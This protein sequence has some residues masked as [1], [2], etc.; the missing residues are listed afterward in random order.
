MNQGNFTVRLIYMNKPSPHRTENPV[1]LD[2]MK[3]AVE[4]SMDGIA[5]L[6]AS[7]K[8][9]YLNEVHIRMF[10]Y[11]ME[12][13]LIGQSWQFIYD[14]PEI[15][16]IDKEIFPVLMKEGKWRGETIGKS[17]TG[18][19]VYQDISLTI[20]DD[21]GI[22]CICRDLAQ[23]IM[24]D[25][26]IRISGKILEQS[27]SMLMTTDKNRNITWVNKAFTTITGYT[28]EEVIGK[29]P[30][31]LLQ[32]PMSKPDTIQQFREALAAGTDFDCELINY[33]KDNSPYWVNIR[34]QAFTDNEGNV[35][36]YFAIEEDITL[37]K[38][39]A[40]L[41]AES[42]RRLEV[43]INATGA[44]LWE[45]DINSNT[46]YYSPT[47]KKVLGYED[48]EIQLGL[49]E[50]LE[51]IHPED[52]TKTMNQLNDCLNGKVDTYEAELRLRHK[53]GH[54]IHVLDRGKITRL[55][56]DGRPSRM[57][58]IAFD[59]TLLKETQQKLKESEA[60]WNA[61]L[62][63]SEFGVWEWDLQSNELYFSPKLKELYGY[64]QDELQPTTAFWTD[65]CHPDDLHDSKNEL[66][67]L[68]S[69]ATDKFK[70]D[71][72]V[73]HRNGQ[74]KWFRSVGVI[75][76]RDD[77]GVPVKLVGSVTDITAQKNM[78]DD[79][80]HAKTVAESNVH[81]KRR[82]LAN[83]SHEIR[84]PIHAV[85]GIAEQLSQTKLDE[86]QRDY[87]SIIEDSSHALLGI[88]NDVLDMAKIE[89]GKLRINNEEFRLRPL[90]NSVYQLYN[91]KAAQKG[92]QFTVE[93]DDTLDRLFMG[94]PFRVRQIILNIVSNAVKFTEKGT[95][96]LKCSCKSV[97][98][99][100]FTVLLEC[101]DT[102][103]GMS[104]DMKQRLFQ[105]FS[106][107]DDSFERRYGGSGL[108][109]AITHEL[110]QL[111]GGTIEVKSDKN[112]G[113]SIGILL[114][115]AGAKSMTEEQPATDDKAT[116]YLPMTS[117]H[118]LIAEDNKFNRL[119]IQIMM[120]NNKIS[121]DLAD[122]GAQAVELASSKKYDLVLMD[123]QMPEMDGVEATKKIRTLPG[124]DLPIIAITANA[125]EEE[126]RSYVEQ[127]MSGYLT[128]PFDEMQL[129]EKIK[130]FIR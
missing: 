17:K 37:R 63:G 12:A 95:I 73:Y 28:I 101:T 109:L 32:G 31:H 98:Q 9:Y 108:G 25:Q 87:V 127:G 130:E 70:T 52:H 90:L 94:D 119:L 121:Y 92:L 16:R 46:V 85:M 118:V 100:Q 68:L 38:Q 99:Q 129:M 113:T 15:E 74:L 111:M 55:D 126:L 120:E 47:W 44:A 30:G 107:E 13:E 114:P 128:K 58:G 2:K 36:G 123:I 82:F 105:D 104:E 79:L 42:N 33:K 116:K 93:F 117:L 48:E 40:E 39:T 106:Q 65:T 18:E 11:E 72:R 6:D 35:E 75:S 78:E 110:V 84:T 69:G 96:Q 122:N 88:I 71:R 19:P 51:R 125:V 1:F 62:E 86:K 10:G 34:C 20:L 29:N 60:R 64:K 54:Y 53:N 103:I 43:A 57:T 27:N 23:R 50:W 41:L 76:N 7:G 112:T 59:I 24:A 66:D 89:E 22:I 21:G 67:K 80:I 3:V 61:A 4:S 56:K 124:G 81:T 115:L 102:G 26:Q 5:L 83:M 91:E 49:N 77:K 97:T 45:W 8:Y 14:K